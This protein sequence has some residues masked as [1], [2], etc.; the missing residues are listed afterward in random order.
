MAIATDLALALDPARLLQSIGMTPDLWQERA[1]RSGAQ[2]LVL[3]CC[4]QSGKSTLAAVLAVH[5]ALFEPGAL[6]LLLSP[7]QRQSQELFR[8]ATA[9]YRSLGKPVPLKEKSALRLELST[10]SRIVSLPGKEQTVRGFSD[11]RLL[12]VDEAARVPDEL[13]YA[14]RPMLAVSGG[15]LLVLST[16][17]GKRGWFFETWKKGEQWERVTVTA[18]QCPRI[19]PAFLEEERVALGARFY[20]QEYEC[21]FEETEGAVFTHEAITA[22]LEP[23]EPPPTGV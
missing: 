1:L 17:F 2:R 11:V 6:V 14:V 19:S 16:P 5:K 15:R 7:S 9:I 8:K 21:S 18:E 23:W 4:R 22:A 3:N 12:V 10:G 20:R 13:Y